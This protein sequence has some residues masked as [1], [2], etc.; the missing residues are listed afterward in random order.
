MDARVVE[1]P[2]QKHPHAAL[3][4]LPHQSCEFFLG[5]EIRVDGK[6]VGGGVLVVKIPGKDGRKIEAVHAQFL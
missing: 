1:H 5:S 6:V 4:G 3:M 2:V